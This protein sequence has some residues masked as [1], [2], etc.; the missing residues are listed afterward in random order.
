MAGPASRSPARRA[1]RSNTGQSSHVPPPAAPGCQAV[2]VRPVRAVRDHPCAVR[3]RTSRFRP[4]A[5]PPGLRVPCRPAPHPE[6]YPHPSPSPHP[7]PPSGARVRPSGRPQPVP[8]PAPPPGRILRSRLRSP[9]PPFPGSSPRRGGRSGTSPFLRPAGP[10]GRNRTP[11]RRR[12]RRLRGAV[13]GFRRR[14]APAGGEPA[15]RT[16]APRIAGARAVAKRSA[17][18]RPR[19]AHGPASR[20]R[21]RVRPVRRPLPRR[22]ARACGSGKP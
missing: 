9:S 11:P 12:S 19:R 15:A 1:P 17:G 7:P 13:S 22:P 20:A 6:P 21:R 16:P 5:G 10:A 18:R 4:R 8:L 14:S 2:T 3:S